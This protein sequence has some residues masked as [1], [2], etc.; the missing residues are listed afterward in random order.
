MLNLRKPANRCLISEMPI[1]DPNRDHRHKDP[2]FT[3]PLAVQALVGGLGA[4][5]LGNMMSG[6][7]QQTSTAPAP[8]VTAPTTMPT[9]GDA[10]TDAAKRKSLSDQLARRGRASTILTDNGVTD[11]LG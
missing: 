9:P 8:T 10:N 7:K 6:D 5:V 2:L 1:G 4:S 3:A 11:T